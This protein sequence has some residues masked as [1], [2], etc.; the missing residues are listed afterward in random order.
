VLNR[1]RKTH[2]DD[3]RSDTRPLDGGPRSGAVATPSK[4]LAVLLER[5]GLYRV[6]AEIDSSCKG[7]CAASTRIAG[8]ADHELDV[9]PSC[10]PV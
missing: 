4:P 1:A 3:H 9:V 10:R 6:D 5:S 7:S 2:S 8:S